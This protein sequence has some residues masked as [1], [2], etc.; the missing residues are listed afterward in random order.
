MTISHANLLLLFC[1]KKNEHQ[2]R[3]KHTRLI[4]FDMNYFVCL[5]LSLFED[6][7]EEKPQKSPQKI[8]KR[9]CILKVLFGCHYYYF[10][11]K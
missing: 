4:M 7:K 2:Q 9:K 1:D 10:F 5:Y 6:E 3:H 8:D 11:L